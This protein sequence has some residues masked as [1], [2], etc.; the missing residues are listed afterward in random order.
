VCL[1]DILKDSNITICIGSNKKVYPSKHFS[2]DLGS[3]TLTDTPSMVSIGAKLILEEE[4][5][6]L[7]A[8]TKLVSQEHCGMES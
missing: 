3:A 8:K 2:R 6:F 4:S 7:S 1:K 5:I